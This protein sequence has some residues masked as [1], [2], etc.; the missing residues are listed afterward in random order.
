[1]SETNQLN[2]ASWYI[3]R[4]KPLLERQ[5]LKHLTKR[6]Y[7]AFVPVQQQLRQWSDRR[8]KVDV[9]LFTGY[10]FVSAQDKNHLDVLNTCYQI[11]STAW[12][13]MFGGKPALLKEHE[14][15]LLQRL[16]ALEEPVTVLSQ[17]LLPG[18]EVEL[19]SGPLKGYTGT[20]VELSGKQRITLRIPGL[21]C[22]AQVEMRTQG[23]KK[24]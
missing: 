19:I 22:A 24:L 2:T 18:D 20:V 8:K 7:D 6:G 1:M 3:I 5:L 15:V 10:V 14:A 12:C 4:V 11:C 13:V 16:A 17:P 9:V 21:Q 23:V